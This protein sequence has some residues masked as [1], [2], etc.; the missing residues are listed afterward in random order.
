MGA[1]VIAVECVIVTTLAV[2]FALALLLARLRRGRPELA[3]GTQFGVGFVLRLLVIAGVAATGVGQTLRGPDELHWLAEAHIL[4]GMSW[5]SPQWLPFDRQ[6]FLHV[7]VFAA[8][9]KA[10]GSPPGAMRIA[11]VAISLAGAMLL[12]AAVHDLAGAK[13]ARVGAWILCLEPA[14]L[15]FSSLLLKEPLMELGGGMLVLGASR[16]WRRLEAR[17]ILL[18]GLG[19][20]IAMG[21]RW[22]I[23]ALLMACAV[24]IL[25]H[26]SLRQASGNIRALPLIYGMVA[27]I[28]ISVPI[29]LKATSHKS[30]EENLQ[31][32]QSAES[33]SGTSTN[34]SGGHLA[35]EKVNF[36]TREAIA[37]NLPARIEDVLLH[38]YP[39]QLSDTSQRLGAIGSIVAL[40]IFALLIRFAIACRGEIMA[41]AGPVIYP[42]L[43][44]LIGYALAT[45]NAGQGFRY[46]THLVTLAIAAMVMLRARALE[47]RAWTDDRAPARGVPASGT[48]LV[49]SPSA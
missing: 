20:A 47:K 19:G 6:S 23:G 43:F 8:Q 32:I 27:V 12:V 44:L 36:S 37:E 49:G 46:R 39:W 11:Q 13:A 35:L 45:G 25:L 48:P 26:A 30:L 28:A 5:S 4:A 38:P 17:G 34:V 9:M 22:Y 40:A 1:A 10:L 14:S 18:M 29:I 31:P 33:T 41:R 7:I 2:G 42:L 24:L 3:I 16:V 15:F 21:A